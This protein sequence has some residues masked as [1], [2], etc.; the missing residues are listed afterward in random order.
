M[1]TV[2]ILIRLGGC[3]GWSEF[4]LGAHAILLVLSWGGSNVTGSF[5]CT[6]SLWDET[7]NLGPR[8]WLLNVGSTPQ[9]WHSFRWWWNPIAIFCLPSIWE[10]GC[11]GLPAF[12]HLLYWE[13]Y[14]WEKWATSWENLFMQYENNKGADQPAHL[15]S[16]ISTFVVR[17]LDSI[18][19]I[20]A[21]SK[22]SRLELASVAEKTG[23]K[24]AW[25]QT[26][27][28]FSRDVVQMDRVKRIWYL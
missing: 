27:D 9:C 17:C 28:R 10:W 23:L 7:L 22:I 3:P 8:Q 13:G 4:S 2:K 1:W 12:S 26:P 21:I 18:I 19:P 15:R 5:L 14:V 11:G 16:L 24:L 20:L 25:S 6:T